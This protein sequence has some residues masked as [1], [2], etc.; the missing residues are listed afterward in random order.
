MLHLIQLEIKNIF[1]QYLSSLNLTNLDYL[2]YC[3]IALSITV[4]FKILH[5]FDVNLEY[6]FLVISAITIICTFSGGNDLIF[7]HIK[8]REYR[9][10]TLYPI[11][12]IKLLSIKLVKFEFIFF[13]EYMFALIPISISLM[14][15]GYSIS[16]VFISMS[17]LIIT[18]A[19]LKNFLLIISIFKT[20]NKSRYLKIFIGFIYISITFYYFHYLTIFSNLVLT[21][22]QNGKYPKT[23]LFSNLSENFNIKNIYY[24]ILCNYKYLFAILFI[25]FLF[26]FIKTIIYSKYS[27]NSNIPVNKKRVEILNFD[28]VR[29]KIQNIML[30]KE[31]FSI[32]NENF[33]EFIINRVFSYILFTAVCILFDLKF[34]FQNILIYIILMFEIIHVSEKI[35]SSFLGKE[36]SFIIN[37]MFSDYSLNKLL[38]FRI[39]IYSLI[40]FLYITFI[41]L[42]IIIILNLNFKEFILLFGT[43]SLLIVP[44]VAVIN[45]FNTY[46]SSY[47]ND[48]GIPNKKSNFIKIMIQSVINYLN[49]LVISIVP[50]LFSGTLNIII[51]VLIIAI[52]NVLYLLFL[53][54]FA[55]LK[56]GDFYG[57]FKVAFSKK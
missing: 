23:N 52:V 16:L 47:I 21:F 13:I 11:I 30:L 27:S 5:T 20:K 15:V 46:K 49:F 17:S 1:K 22:L 3:G 37:Y 40:V 39:K 6:I 8:S 33:F 35:S 54:G 2:I 36:K 34:N 55:K 19:C 9:L 4:I 53:W 56:E 29:S 50:I 26:L 42:L 45:I 57:E 43:I 12:H 10:S 25:Y 7:K 48:L 14:V 31:L 51:Q 41:N 32:K 38:S 44:Q 28:V 24:C 18:C